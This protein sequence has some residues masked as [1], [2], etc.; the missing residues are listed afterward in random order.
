MT[1]EKLTLLADNFQHILKIDVPAYV[2]FKEKSETTNF[3]VTY[4]ECSNSL[5]DLSLLVTGCRYSQ[6]LFR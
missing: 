4:K 2:S 5:C 6:R 1:G 3:N